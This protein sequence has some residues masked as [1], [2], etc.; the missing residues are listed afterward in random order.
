M[1]FDKLLAKDLAQYVEN[2]YLDWNNPVTPPN[3]SICTRLI[4]DLDEA[5]N[6]IGLG[7]SEGYVA[8]EDASSNKKNVYIILLGTNHISD[9][10]LDLQLDLIPYPNFS[11]KI[12]EGFYEAWKQIRDQIFNCIDPIKDDVLNIYVSGHSYG[13]AVGEIGL[14]E[15]QNRY[16]SQV[17]YYGFA[18]PRVGDQDFS[19]YMRNKF[20]NRFEILYVKD[21]VPCVPSREMG[22]RHCEPVLIVG[23]RGEL[24]E[25]DDVFYSGNDLETLIN[26]IL[27]P[28][29]KEHEMKTYVNLM[30]GTLTPLDPADPKAKK[31]LNST[32]KRS[33]WDRCVIL[34]IFRFW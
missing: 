18:V 34:R 15:I 7:N 12:H 13:A 23:K 16:S 3:S 32:C 11:G 30:N 19:S 27:G 29:R 5:M 2:L 33:I 21:I 9:I 22:Y 8:I 10:W 20:Q 24:I 1:T 28:F 14:P 31:I 4:V 25:T 17:Y 26:A 6:A